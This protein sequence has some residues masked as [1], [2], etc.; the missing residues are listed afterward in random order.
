M[1]PVP[2]LS[3]NGWNNFICLERFFTVRS[4][5][6]IC[7][8]GNHGTLSLE[9]QP[10][11]YDQSVDNKYLPRV[12]VGGG[13]ED[14]GAGVTEGRSTMHLLIMDRPVY[15]ISL[16][17]FRTCLL[18]LRN[19]PQA[20]LPIFMKLSINFLV[21]GLPSI[22]CSLFYELHKFMCQVYDFYWGWV[23]SNKKI[24]TYFLLILKRFYV[25]DDMGNSFKVDN[26]YGSSI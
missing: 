20:F 4:D 14:G 17:P 25:V 1:I 7:I 15:L 9:A 13:K 11:R 6:L 3:L 21:L 2:L 8:R 18:I 12:S 26:R 5:P 23:I 10:D 24:N 16:F 22:T 19:F